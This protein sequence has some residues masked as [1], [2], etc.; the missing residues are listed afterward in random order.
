[1]LAWQFPAEMLGNSGLETLLDPIQPPVDLICRELLMGE[2]SCQTGGWEAFSFLLLIDPRE[3][4]D[5]CSFSR[6]GIVRS[7]GD[8]PIRIPS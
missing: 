4:E 2:S 7:R 1:M 3:R 6:Q 8:Q 5:V